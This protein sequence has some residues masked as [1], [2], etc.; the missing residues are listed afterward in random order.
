LDDILNIQIPSSN[1]AG[2]G[3]DH[4]EINKRLNYETQKSDKNP[5][6]YAVSLQSSFK[7][8]KNQIKTDSTQQRSALSPKRNEYKINTTPRITP[9]KRYQQLFLSSYFSC[10]NFGHKALD[11]KA[12][13]N[14]YHKSVHGY[15]H[16]NNKSNRN[17]RSRNYN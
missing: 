1:K 17:Q 16:R 7:R 14:D 12:Y 10:H 2:L 15:S 5:K 4:N 6:T 9:P 3:Y 13:K 8:E 11:C